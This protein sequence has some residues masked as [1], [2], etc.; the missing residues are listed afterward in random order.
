M[1]T[2]RTSSI[3]VS[4]LYFA[5]RSQIAWIGATTADVL[6]YARSHPCFPHEPTSD[7]F[8]DEAQFESYRRLGE[9]TARRALEPAFERL[10]G[11][12]DGDGDGNSGAGQDR[13][14]P[15]RPG[16]HDSPARDRLL[17]AL[18]QH[19]AMPPRQPSPGAGPGIP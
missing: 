19:W 17:A 9:D 4:A 1:P 16:L 6:H 8:F 3:K 14:W 5:A 15:P 10:R 11:D 13:P 12:H 7:Q 18:R 2:A